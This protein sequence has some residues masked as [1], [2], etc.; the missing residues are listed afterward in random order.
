MHWRPRNR[1]PTS[2][3][4]ESENENND[5]KELTQDNPTGN[6]NL[7]KNINFKIKMSKC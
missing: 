7:T 2:V 6:D 4:G 5:H 1:E 3:E